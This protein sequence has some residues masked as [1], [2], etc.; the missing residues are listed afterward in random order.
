MVPQKSISWEDA[1]TL[2]YQKKAIILEEYDETISS[3]SMTMFVPAVIKLTQ[4]FKTNQKAIRFSRVNMLARDG[5]RCQY[6]GEKKTAKD[7][8]YDHVI[9]RRHGGKTTWDNVCISC[10]RCNERKGGRTPEEAGMRLLK[11]PARPHK[12]PLHTVFM[13]PGEIPEP[14][15]P[16]LQH[17]EQHGPGYY[18]SKVG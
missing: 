18:I 12:L 16:Y 4:Q 6:C 17:L 10:I 2:Y 7:L 1:V 14:W 11:K 13:I 8:N 9:P 3:P 5:Y 15:K